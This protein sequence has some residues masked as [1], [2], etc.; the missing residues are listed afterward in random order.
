MNVSDYSLFEL[1]VLDLFYW[2]MIQGLIGFISAHLPR[3]LIQP[4]RH[5]YQVRQW[6]KDGAIYQKWFNIKKWKPIVWD[7]GKFFQKDFSK[8]HVD[9]KNPKNLERWIIETCRAEWCHWVTFFFILPL[10][11]F[12]PSGLMYFWFLYDATLNIVPIIVQR[13]NRPRLMR[14]L[15]RINPIP[16]TDTVRKWYSQV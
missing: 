1:F 3:R 8:D 12:N 6:E 5:I 13:Y 9:P 14:L 4:T 7:A 10:F 2:L 15:E 16:Q 11:S